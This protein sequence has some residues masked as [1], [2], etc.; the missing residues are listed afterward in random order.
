MGRGLARFKLK[1]WRCDE[2]SA[3]GSRGN[4]MLGGWF[5][6][7]GDFKELLRHVDQLPIVH[8]IGTVSHDN[9]TVILWPKVL[10][11]QAA[12]VVAKVMASGRIPG[13]LWILPRF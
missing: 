7:W 1:T 13:Q 9:R 11:A 12:M 4:M 8:F 2:P 6:A 10:L 5:L 3:R